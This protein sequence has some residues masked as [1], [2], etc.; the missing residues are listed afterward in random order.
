[1]QQHAARGSKL[2]CS[3]LVASVLQAA[4]NVS[5]I[6]MLSR[7]ATLVVPAILVI[8]ELDKSTACS[9]TH[10]MHS[11]TRNIRDREVPGR[12]EAAR[13]RAPEL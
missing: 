13:M 4:S 8:V 6:R 7:A 3:L 5:I 1:M 10:T 12:K 11:A 2:A 9:A